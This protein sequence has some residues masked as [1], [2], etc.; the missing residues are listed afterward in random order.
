MNDQVANPNG[1]A[2]V[3][4]RPMF[5]DFQLLAAWRVKDAL[6]RHPRGASVPSRRQRETEEAFREQRSYN[7][8]LAGLL[9]VVLSANPSC[10]TRAVSDPST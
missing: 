6:E 5:I 4:Q 2:S 3:N 9:R 1:R 10:C 7:A 8:P